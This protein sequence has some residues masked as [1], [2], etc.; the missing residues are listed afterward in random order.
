MYV[1]GSFKQN[2]K[3]IALTLWYVLTSLGLA[4][5]TVV[6][7]SPL[8]YR[9]QLEINPLHLQVGLTKSRLMENYGEMM[10]YLIDPRVSQLIMPDFSSSTNG[11]Q[12]FE[13][14]KLLIQLLLI[15]TLILLVVTIISIIL[16]RHSKYKQAFLKQFLY[17]AV[18]LPFLVIFM[19]I[20]AFDQIFLWFHLLL[21][22]NDYWLFNPLTDPIINVLPQNFFMILFILTI[23][24]YEIFLLLIIKLIRQK[25]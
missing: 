9:L 22:N 4:I 7:V 14:V 13:E 8:F 23:F 2:I 15:F 1:L 3:N 18:F 25:I 12:H 24:L 6:F 21:F 19:I 20:V 17:S 10:R 16:I 11:L 5:T